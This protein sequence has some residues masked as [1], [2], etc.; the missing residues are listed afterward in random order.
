[1]LAGAIVL[2]VFVQVYLIGSYI[3]GAGQGALDAHKSVGFTVHGFEVLLFLAAPLAWLPRVDLVLS[4]LLAV[5]GT[6][7]IGFAGADKWVG[8]LHPVGALFVL[9]LATCLCAEAWSGIAPPSLLSRGRMRFAYH[10]DERLA[11]ALHQLF[12]P[13]ALGVGETHAGP[14]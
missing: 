6:L 2:G 13:I 11:L 8:G 12:S 5:C 7:Q 9:V 14:R 3:F 1:M 10:P 4:M